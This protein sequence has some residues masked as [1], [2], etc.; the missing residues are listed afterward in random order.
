[1]ATLLNRDKKCIAD[2]LENDISL[3]NE[4]A[5]EEYG[6]PI[7]IWHENGTYNIDSIHEIKLK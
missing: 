6:V 4:V 3:C 1:M 7:D 5:L 2:Y